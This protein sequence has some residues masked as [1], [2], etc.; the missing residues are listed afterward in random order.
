MLDTFYTKFHPY[1]ENTLA[2]KSEHKVG[3]R[4]LGT[5]PASGKQV[6]VKIGKFGPVAQIEA[7]RKTKKSRDSHS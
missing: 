5:D 1:V 4:I 6:S 2:T 7:P 3:E